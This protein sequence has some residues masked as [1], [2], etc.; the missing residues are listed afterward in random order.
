MSRQYKPS[1]KRKVPLPF[2]EKMMKIENPDKVAW[3]DSWSDTGDYEERSLLNFPKGSKIC[4]VGPA[5]VGKS[6]LITVNLIPRAH[7]SFVK[8]IVVHPDAMSQDYESLFNDNDDDD[9]SVVIRSD[10][11]SIKEWNEYV[12]ECRDENGV[13]GPICCILDDIEYDTMKKDQRKSLDHLMRYISSHKNV[14]VYITCQYY[15]LLP[16][17]IRRNSNVIFL[18]PCIDKSEQSMVAKKVGLKP[19]T[20]N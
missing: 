6:N 20:L 14:S 1:L 2:Q 12:E 18:W 4:I 9:E 13:N 16:L 3:K 19:G 5:G 15:H 10:I 7:P 11:P 8:I 17:I